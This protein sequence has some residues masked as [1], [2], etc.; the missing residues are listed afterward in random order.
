MFFQAPR[1]PVQV[2]AVLL[3]GC[4]FEIGQDGRIRR[5]WVDGLR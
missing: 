4:V 3:G 5:Q 2:E 1:A